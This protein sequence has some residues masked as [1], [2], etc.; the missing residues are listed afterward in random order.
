MLYSSFT[1]PPPQKAPLF[2]AELLPCLLHQ[3]S[4]NRPP[5]LSSN[6][7]KLEPH[8]LPSGQHETTDPKEFFAVELGESM[9]KLETLGCHNSLFLAV[10]RAL[11][12]KIHYENQNYVDTLRKAC[13]SDVDFIPAHCFDSDLALQELLRRALCLFWLRTVKQN[14]SNLSKTK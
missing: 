7:I 8:L 2:T 1:P 4:S 11:L 5:R 3:N 14:Y 9:Q 13:F 12:F 6:P 10:A